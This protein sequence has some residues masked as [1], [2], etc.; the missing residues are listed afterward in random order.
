MNVS[1]KFTAQER[2]KFKQFIRTKRSRFG[3]KIYELCTSNG[4]TLDFLVYCGPGMYDDDLYSDF[5]ASER[6]PM[7][8]MEPFVG[9]GHVLFTDN[10]YTSP[11]LAKHFLNHSTHLCGTIKFT[12]KNFSKDISKEVLEKGKAVFYKCNEK[13]I[14]AIKYRAVKDKANKKPK[15]VYLLS[16][17]HQPMMLQVDAYHPTGDAV[18]KPEAIKAYNLHMGGVD[19]VDQQLHNIRSMRKTYKW[20]RKLAI[21]LILQAVLNAHKVYK[22]QTG[23]DITLLKLLHDAIAELVS[24]APANLAPV[25]VNDTHERL[26]GRH[27]ISIRKPQPGAKDQRPTKECRVCRARKI[28]TNKGTAVKTVYICPQCPT[29]PG[30]HPGDCFRAYH[31]QLDYSDT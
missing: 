6:I 26:S 31:T 4:I 15:V 10:F 3:I 16:T 9:K 30:L 14:I 21:R 24:Q 12:R 28:T 22:F 7:V 17:C 8:L 13:K 2:Q 5:P 19:L 29:E 18:F 25:P 23:S 20:Y 11:L 27:F 1:E